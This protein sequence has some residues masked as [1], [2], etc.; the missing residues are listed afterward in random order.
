MTEFPRSHAQDEPGEI[1]DSDVGAQI[2]GPATAN[3]TRLEHAG[4]ACRSLAIFGTWAGW[5][6][7]ALGVVAAVEHV[8]ASAAVSTTNPARFT[9]AVLGALFRLLAFCLAGRGVAVITRMTASTIIERLEHA[10][11]AFEFQS[12]GLSQV[13]AQLERLVGSSR[14]PVGPAISS[15]E[16]SGE[17]AQSIAEIARATQA[18]NWLVAQT[19]L[20]ELEASFPNDPEL[21]RLREQLVRARHDAIQMT[22]SQLSAARDVND[23]DRVLE[24][25]QVVHPSLEQTERIA[26]ERDLAKWFLSL[27]HRRLRL[28]KVQP[29]VVHLAS[30]F[31]ETFASTVE[32]ASVRA[33]LSTLRRSIGLCPRCGHPYTGIAEA[34]PKCLKLSSNSSA[35]ILGEPEMNEPE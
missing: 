7:A 2:S 12:I 17:R 30:R 6:L 9:S 32:G 14:Q 22:L 23:P 24:I 28:G 1:H 11:R 25:Y 31:S 4:S 15:L 34:C 21:T 27:I 13:V 3:P 19:R 8:L 33:S 10:A 16:S 35:T 20:D 29:D 5:G 18:A 26:L